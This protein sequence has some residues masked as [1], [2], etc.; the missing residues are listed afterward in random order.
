MYHYFIS[1]TYLA[2][3]SVSLCRCI[4]FFPSVGRSL[5]TQP[6]TCEK[7]GRKVVP[8]LSA[9]RTPPVYNQEHFVRRGD[10]GKTNV[11]LKA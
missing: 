7:H 4:F 8:L 2:D 10:S 9:A 1:C 3:N 11:P 5:T 6:A